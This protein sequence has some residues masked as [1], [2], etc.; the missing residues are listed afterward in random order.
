MVPIKKIA[1]VSSVFN[2]ISFENLNQAIQTS[3]KSTRSGRKQRI[4]P[5]EKTIFY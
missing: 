2:A 4:S 5:V 3:V 1:E